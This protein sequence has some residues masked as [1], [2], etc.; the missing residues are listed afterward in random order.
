M[1]C[2]PR[3]LEK[4]IFKE[5]RPLDFSDLSTVEQIPLDSIK[6]GYRNWK[7]R[8]LT[9]PHSRH[10]GIFKVWLFESK[11]ERDNRAKY[12]ALPPEERKERDN[13]LTTDEFFSIIQDIMNLAIHLNHPLKRWNRVNVYM[14]PKDVG[15]PKPNRIRY[16]NQFDSEINLLRRII[17][18][19]RAMHNAE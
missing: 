8:T 19:Q 10:L 13:V 18:S 12:Y 2:S 16:L 6:D 4:D 3:E 9:S 5:L 1:L 11:K 14:A 15:I 17:I 7:E